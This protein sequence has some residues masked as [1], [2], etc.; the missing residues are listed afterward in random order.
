MIGEL[1]YL[2]QLVCLNE[3]DWCD[4]AGP[5]CTRDFTQR[6]CRRYCQLCVGNDSYNRSLNF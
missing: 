4:E 2:F 1:K 5:D 3:E 6:S